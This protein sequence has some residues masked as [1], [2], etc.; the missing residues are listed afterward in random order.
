MNRYRA[1]FREGA[2]LTTF[3]ETKGGLQVHTFG[4]EDYIKLYEP[5]FMERGVYEK[6]VWSRSDSYLL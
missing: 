6:E 2:Q 5:S 4:V 3:A 1:L